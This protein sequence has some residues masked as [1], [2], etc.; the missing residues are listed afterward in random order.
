M[1][2]YIFKNS[3]RFFIVFI[4]LTF[5]FSS[6]T[7]L[8]GGFCV[9]SPCNPVYDRVNDY[10]A[11]GNSFDN[12]FLAPT[13]L[14]VPKSLQLIDSVEIGT[15]H[16]YS[17]GFQEIAFD[18]KVDHIEIK[19]EL[20][21]KDRRSLL[22]AWL[23]IKL[24]IFASLP[25]WLLLG[26]GFLKIGRKNTK[27]GLLLITIYTIFFSFPKFMDLMDVDSHANVF[28]KLLFG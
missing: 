27:I 22:L 6:F 14:L 25:W 1:N 28:F 7:S 10:D 23:I 13:A 18:R 9:T 24:T 17:F 11:F 4:V 21:V 5:F 2:D 26:W 20:I 15:W 3:K 12:I 8:R 19:E 16:K